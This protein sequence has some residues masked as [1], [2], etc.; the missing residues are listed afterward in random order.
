MLILYIIGEGVG[1]G[2]GGCSS[3]FFHTK[4]ILKKLMQWNKSQTK[5]KKNREKWLY[6]W[7]GFYVYTS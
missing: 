3:S 6:N 4:K 1:V 2:Y 7:Y 5:E